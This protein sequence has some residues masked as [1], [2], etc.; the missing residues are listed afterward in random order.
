M[1]VD[2]VVPTAHFLHFI[3][4]NAPVQVNVVWNCVWI[5]VVSELWKHRNN[6]IFQGGVI[7]PSEVFTLAQRLGLG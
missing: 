5:V 7:Y 3:L 1:S 4:L 2:H 6:H